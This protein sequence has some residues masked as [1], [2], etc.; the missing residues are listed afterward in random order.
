MCVP[1]V[2]ELMKQEMKEDRRRKTGRQR[3]TER[4]QKRRQRKT[5]KEDRDRQ[6][7]EDKLKIPVAVRRT[8]LCA[9]GTKLLP[10]SS[11]NHLHVTSSLYVDEMQY[12]RMHDRPSAEWEPEEAEPRYYR[13]GSAS[14]LLHASLAASVSPG[15]VTAADRT[16]LDERASG[17]GRS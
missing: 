10:T 5:E 16:A 17:T 15:A 8:A 9:V 14:V 3:K 7:K 2:L 1:K 11:T 13:L 6:A 12:R 4:R